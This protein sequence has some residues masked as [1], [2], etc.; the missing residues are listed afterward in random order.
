[1]IASLLAVPLA[2]CGDASA[3]P[4]ATAPATVPAGAFGG[5]DLAWIEINIAMDEQLMP[6]L[7]L[8]P[9]HTANPDVRRIA[10]DVGKACTS[11]LAT[12]RQLRD[13]AKLPS[14]NPHEGMPMPGMVTPA[15][16]AAAAAVQG[17][18]FDALVLAG[19]REHLDQGSKLAGSETKAGSEGR[20]LALARRVL[21]VRGELV[22]AV[23]RLI[24]K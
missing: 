3:H 18:A 1:L 4:S 10:D 9:G 21:A 24:G 17:P 6:L 14:A 19:L 15:Q 13:Q 22:P 2:A 16:V 5:T 20:T 23:G 7:D 11:E 8:V 12:L